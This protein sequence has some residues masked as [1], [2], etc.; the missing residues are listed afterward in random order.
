[1]IVAVVEFCAYDASGQVWVHVI[2]GNSPTSTEKDCVTR[3][4]YAIDYWQILGY[5]TVHDL[6]DITLRFGNSGE[7]VLAL[8]RSLVA[9]GLLEAQYT[10][11][12][13]G[14]I[15]QGAITTLQRQCRIAETGIANHETQW[16]LQ[17]RVEEIQSRQAPSLPSGQ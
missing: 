16:A 14:A 7:K 17:Q 12:Q 5:G 15:T 4:A 13:Y 9:V 10:T 2:E 1:M 3:N 6:A 11:G 8:Q